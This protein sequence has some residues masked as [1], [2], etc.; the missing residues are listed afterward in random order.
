MRPGVVDEAVAEAEEE[1]LILWPRT[2]CNAPESPYGRTSHGRPNYATV[3]MIHHNLVE[4]PDESGSLT[5]L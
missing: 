1:N 2:N 5:K 3:K 4:V